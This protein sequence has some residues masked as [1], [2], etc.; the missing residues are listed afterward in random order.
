[1]LARTGLSEKTQQVRA[2][3]HPTL[4]FR[5]RNYV[6]ILAVLAALTAGQGCAA[7]TYRASSLPPEFAAPPA[8]DVGTLNLSGLVNNSVSVDV[9]QPGDVLD[10]NMVTDY[11]KLETSTTPVRVS[12]DGMV[13]VPLVGKV[14]VGGLEVVQAERAINA[15]SI[16]R[17]VFRNPCIT[18]TMKQCHTKKVT[19]LG[20]VNQPGPRDLPRGATSLLAAINAAGGLSKEASMNVEIRH[21]DSRQAISALPPTSPVA[22]NDDDGKVMPASFQQTVPGMPAPAVTAIDLKEAIA[23]TIQLPE[24]RDGDVVNVAKRKFPPVF[25]LGLVRKPGEVEYPTSQEL[26]VLDALAKGEGVSN[27]LAEDIIVIRQVKG[28]PEPVRISVSLQGAKNGRDNIVLAPGD[29][30]TVE[31]TP[32]TWVIDIFQTVIRVSVGGSLSWF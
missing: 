10:I 25:V 8:L 2:S 15:E 28:A 1:V 6:T 5:N 30:V 27:P 9:I 11:Q 19:V 26:R 24:L 13:V 22:A 18:V 16:T 12:D 17:G 4:C 23:G 3:T 31:Q 7:R 20:A 14:S 21:T 29:M 32:A